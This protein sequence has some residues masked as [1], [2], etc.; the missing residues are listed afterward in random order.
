VRKQS[1][2]GEDTGA[3]SAGLSLAQLSAA[4]CQDVAF[5]F[6]TGFVTEVFRLLMQTLGVR[7]KRELS[8]VDLLR[9]PGRSV[10]VKSIAEHTV[11]EL[12]GKDRP[13]LLSEVSA[14]LTETG[15]NVNAAEVWTHNLRA[16]FV[17]YVTDEETPGPIANEKNLERIK[18]LLFKVMKG[19]SNDEKRG[20]ERGAKSDIATEVTHTERRLHQMMFADRDYE[21]LEL[22]PA[23]RCS[24]SGSSTVEKDDKPVIAIQSRNERG[25]SV[26]N[27]ACKDRPKLLFDIVCTLTDMQ[28]VVF[29]ATINSKGTDAV[30]VQFHLLLQSGRLQVSQLFN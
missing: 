19:G 13:G 4:N 21:A 7:M 24:T 14:V 26:I 22:P 29:H 6:G 15:C 28:Y 23:P 27:V 20:G 9:C 17:L 30:Q 3:Y 18:E 16:A 12:T 1:L 5:L 10:G 11:I 25:Y 8:S 2:G